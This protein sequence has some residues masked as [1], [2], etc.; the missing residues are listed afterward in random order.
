VI[1]GAGTIELVELKGMLH[2]VSGAGDLVPHDTSLQ[3]AESSLN[4][5]DMRA[6]TGEGNLAAM[7]D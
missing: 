2:A 7:S 5:G 1:D 6:Y 3:E 4:P